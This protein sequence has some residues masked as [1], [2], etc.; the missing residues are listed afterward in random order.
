M[1]RLLLSRIS[2]LANTANAIPSSGLGAV[3]APSDAAI[4]SEAHATVKPEASANTNGTTDRSNYMLGALRGALEV[5][6]GNAVTTT[7]A[8]FH[9]S[10][11]YKRTSTAPS[12]MRPPATATRRNPTSRR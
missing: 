12:S 10:W 9:S 5:N 3:D 2:A 4:K 11:A 7:R 6:K 8:T 1:H